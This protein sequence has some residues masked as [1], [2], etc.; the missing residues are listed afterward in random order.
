MKSKFGFRIGLSGLAFACLLF[1]CG[2]FAAT[3]PLAA[4]LTCENFGAGNDICISGDSDT[5]LAASAASAVQIVGAHDMLTN[6]DL[7]GGAADLEN[8]FVAGTVFEDATAVDELP[9]TT[10][11]FSMIQALRAEA[12]IRNIET[13]FATTTLVTG[14][15]VNANSRH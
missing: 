6:E 8:E 1:A 14:A 2:S 3:A 12:Q 11:P 7:K 4:S 10:L 9:S 13:N 15:T 5:T